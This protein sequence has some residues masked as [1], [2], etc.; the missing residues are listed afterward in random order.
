LHYFDS[1]RQTSYDVA[2]CQLRELSEYVT[3][4][5]NSYN[6][7]NNANSIFITG[8]FNLVNLADNF[9]CIT[10]LGFVDSHDPRHDGRR[11][12]I[13]NESRI[14]DH[15]FMKNVFGYSYITDHFG[16]IT[17]HYAVL[18]VF[19]LSPSNLVFE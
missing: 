15:I 18:G 11:T 8:D 5:I 10:D 1:Q 4:Y 7:D 3:Y 17:D 2:K 14:T 13:I 19:E 12:T 6:K 9:K 16:D